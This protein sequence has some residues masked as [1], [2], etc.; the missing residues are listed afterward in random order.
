MEYDQ[1]VIVQFLCKER[2]S[3]EDIHARL[4]AE[5]GDATYTEYSERSVRR[6]CQYVR[7]GREDLHE[8]QS[9][10]PPIDF[11][12]IR[13]LALLDEQSFCSAYS[14]TE[15]LVVA[16]STVLSHLRKS[17]AMRNFHLR[18][19]SHELTTNLQQVRMETCR[20]VLPILK[21]HKRNR[22]QRFVTGDESWFTLEFHH[23]TKWSV[24]RNDAP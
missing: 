15:T 2:V 23:S 3:P 12:N 16:H 4:E 18:W 20:E 6:W 10:S 7:Q 22:N 21:G 14:I 17:L 8:V 24:S 9:G 19:I 11:M 5:F 13:I 1:K